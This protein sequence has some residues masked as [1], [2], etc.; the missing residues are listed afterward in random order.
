MKRPGAAVFFSI[1]A[2]FDFAFG[3]FKGHAL[4]AG[5]GQNLYDLNR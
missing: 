5:V 1:C 3:Y 4:W 2:V